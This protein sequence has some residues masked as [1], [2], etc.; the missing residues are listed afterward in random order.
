MNAPETP[1]SEPAAVVER[2]ARRKSGSLYSILRPEVIL[3]TQ[4]WQREMLYLLGSTCG[5]SVEDLG[6]LKVVDV[7]C[8]F[9]GH[10]LDFM[11]FGIAPH[12]LRGIELLADRFA[13]A[14]TR[15]PP[16]ILIHEGDAN[17]AD[18]EP[19]SQDIVFQSVVFSSLLSD[20]F[21]QELADRMWSWVRPGGGVLWYDFV[22]GNPNNADVRAVPVKR[23]RELFPEGRVV[24]RRVTLAPP[25]SRRVCKIHPAAY[26]LFNMFP[27]LRTHALCWIAKS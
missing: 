24:V 27:F 16:T 22:Y 25:I 12:N 15:V 1:A 11:R 9:G 18:I 5:Y 23:V 14:R 10:L 20:S 21:Q 26:H 13:L 4:E 17:S 8:G 2:Y 7:G 19:A 3:S 6:G